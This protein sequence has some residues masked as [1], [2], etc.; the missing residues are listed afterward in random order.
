MMQPNK[1]LITIHDNKQLIEN[2]L[3]DLVLLPRLKAL[4][5]SKITK[6]TPNMKVGYPGQHL[7]S[8]ALGM[9]GVRTGARGHDIVDGSEVK[10]CSRVDALDSCVDC[11]EKVLR[12]ETQCSN[13]D[14]D[15]IKRSN[16]SKW[17]FIIRSEKDIDT[18]LNDVDRIVLVMADYPY[19][20]NG[21]FEDLRFQIFEIWTKSQRC[22][23]FRTIINN[24][25]HKIYLEHKEKNP[26][27]T[28]APKNFWPFSYQFYM[29]NP[30]KILSCMVKDANTK[31][32]I[33]IEYFVEPETDRSKLAAEPMPTELLSKEEL[34]LLLDLPP[35]VLKSLV[36]NNSFIEVM[37]E[38]QK[39]KPDTKKIQAMMPYLSEEARS[40]LPLRDTDKISEA[41][42]QYQRK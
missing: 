11:G 31:P 15:N 34:S 37:K 10:S 4:E 3:M 17:L 1:T 40:I 19:F 25:Y 32:K 28:P 9:E 26:A 42:S 23:H 14:S 33:D 22:T 7:A 36:F 20:A 5:W 27:K 12:L 24:Y 6:Q 16:D 2:L 41:K 35:T 38:L 30:I 18:L 8:L 21:N 39:T 13:C 29:C